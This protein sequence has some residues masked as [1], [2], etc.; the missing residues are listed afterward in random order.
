MAASHQLFGF[1][2]LLV[3]FSSPLWGLLFFLQHP[4]PMWV[5]IHVHSKVLGVRL[6]SLL[7]N[8]SWIQLASRGGSTHL[9]AWEP[10]EAEA[11]VHFLP[12]IRG[13]GGVHCW[14]HQGR[15][16]LQMHS[17]HSLW[18]GKTLV[19]RV[20]LRG[21]LSQATD[22]WWKTFNECGKVE[23]PPKLPN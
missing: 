8:R 19:K 15:T 9:P 20:V 6:N 17:L 14:G 12:L 1:E 23:H 13:C 21:S 3:I 11:L 5:L 22:M 10:R 18:E 2:S 7:P 16:Q 4:F